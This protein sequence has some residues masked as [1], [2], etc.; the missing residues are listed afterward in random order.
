[1]ELQGL[2]PKY[3]ITKTADGSE[4]E[5]AFVLKP[6]AD[7]HARIAL[8]WYA[9]SVEDENPALAGELREWVWRLSKE[10]PLG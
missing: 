7:P 9:R 1:M 2:Y 10:L 3:H 5:N 6:E 8:L 4:V